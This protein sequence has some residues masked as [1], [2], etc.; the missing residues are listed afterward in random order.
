MGPLLPTEHEPDAYGFLPNWH[1]TGN[2]A[3]HTGRGGGAKASES[4]SAEGIESASVVEHI[5][6]SSTT[7]LAGRIEERWYA[8]LNHANCL[9]PYLMLCRNEKLKYLVAC[10]C[11]ANRAVMVA[12]NKAAH[13]SLSYQ[14]LEENVMRF[15]AERE[16]LRGQLEGVAQGTEM[17]VRQREEYRKKMDVHRDQVSQS[18]I[19]V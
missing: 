4:P 12:K 10:V 17:G 8:T 15:V 16:D 19:L 3:N 9:L 5:L 6:H 14:H 1:S 18:D 2:G 13:T 7:F 11:S